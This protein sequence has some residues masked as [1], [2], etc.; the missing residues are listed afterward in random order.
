[1]V[2]CI[3][4]IMTYNVQ[5]CLVE[6][7]NIFHLKLILHTLQSKDGLKRNTGSYYY[8]LQLTALGHGWRF[9]TY[10]FLKPQYETRKQECKFSTENDW[11]PLVFT[12]H[13]FLLTHFYTSKML[14][15]EKNSST[16][17]ALLGTMTRWIS[18]HTRRYHWISAESSHPHYK[19]KW[20]KLRLIFKEYY[21][22][23][24]FHRI[25]RTLW[26]FRTL[27]LLKCSADF[28]CPSRSQF[29]FVDTKQWTF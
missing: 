19:I 12:K 20:M 3:C 13:I 17:G 26:H 22:W 16:T 14:E 6:F 8:R 25:W 24:L 2:I 18:G 23:R 21:C 27:N 29:D 10:E 28:N 7:I 9:G 5:S 1:M 15:T 4:I 11:H